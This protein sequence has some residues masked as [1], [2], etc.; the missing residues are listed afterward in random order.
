MTREEYLSIDWKRGNIVKLT[1]GKEYVVRAVKKKCLLL[2]SDE[3]YSYFVADHRIIDCRTSDATEIKKEERPDQYRPKQ[4]YR[5]QQYRPQRQQNNRYHNNQYRSNQYGG[6]QY[7]G[8]QYGNSTYRGA[9][10]RNSQPGEPPY[11]NRP[12]NNRYEQRWNNPNGYA[13]DGNNQYRFNQRMDMGG[14]NGVADS[15]MAPQF[16]QANANEMFAPAASQP[17]GTQELNTSAGNAPE[18]QDSTV[19]RKR[20]RIVV[21]KTIAEKVEYKPR[22]NQE[23]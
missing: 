4:Q 19:K 21:K 10:Y 23:Q 5:T 15:G 2:H 9:Q 18:L 8:N 3:F 20:Q 22:E 1:N 12:Y 13:N 16:Q 6:Q 7:R 11:G 14:A 17:V